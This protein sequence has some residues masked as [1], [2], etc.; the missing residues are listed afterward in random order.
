MPARVPTGDGTTTRRRVHDLVVAMG[1]EEVK[2]MNNVTRARLREFLARHLDEVGARANEIRRWWLAFL[3]A[4]DEPKSRKGRACKYYLELVEVA[5][6]DIAG[7]SHVVLLDEV[8]RLVLE[9]QKKVTE[10]DEIEGFFVPVKNVW[11]VESLR[12]EVAEKD[13]AL[14]EKD[15]ALAEKDAALAEERAKV[16]E[17]DATL[18]EKDAQIE[19]LRTRLRERQ[20]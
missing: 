11:I 6:P 16:A 19:E 8:D 4:V 13:A 20:E 17:K 5:P 15:A 1:P 7:V 9:A 14:A 18:A 10:E 3:R 2:T 12:E